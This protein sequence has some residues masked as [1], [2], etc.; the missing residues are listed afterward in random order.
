M[1][2]IINI[3]E[4]IHNFCMLKQWRSQEGGSIMKCVLGLLHGI[5][6]LDSSL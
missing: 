3:E 2:L 1:L 4:Q 6:S 5:G